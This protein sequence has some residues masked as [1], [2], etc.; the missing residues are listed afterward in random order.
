MISAAV[1]I[2]GSFLSVEMRNGGCPFSSRETLYRR[3][4]KKPLT[5]RVDGCVYNNRCLGRPQTHPAEFL[6]AVIRRTAGEGI[7]FGEQSR[8][9]AGYFLIDVRI[10]VAPGRRTVKSEQR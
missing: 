10:D 7:F 3:I 6:F 2:G 5:G 4:F 8:G 1:S 9:A